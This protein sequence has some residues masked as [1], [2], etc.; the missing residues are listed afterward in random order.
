VAEQ[1]AA[2]EQLSVHQAI[3]QRVG[4][5]ERKFARRREVLVGARGIHTT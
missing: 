2:D 4:E 1:P 3:A 5:P